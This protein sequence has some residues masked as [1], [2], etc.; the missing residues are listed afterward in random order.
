MVEGMTGTVTIGTVM[1]A[2]GEAAQCR[3]E[4]IETTLHRTVTRVMGQTEIVDMDTMEV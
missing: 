2:N 3:D 4:D 1:E